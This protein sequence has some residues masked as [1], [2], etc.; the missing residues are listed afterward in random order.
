MITKDQFG[1][2]RHFIF[3]H[4]R[5]F[6][7]KRFAY[8]FEGGSRLAAL[9]ALLCYQNPDG[10]FGHGLELDVI[11]AA[12]APICAE[13]ALNHFD[14]LGA[15]DCDALRQLEGWIL[16]VQREDGALPNPT[17]EIARHPHGPWWLDEDA[18]RA[19]SLAGLLAKMGLGSEEFFR[20]VEGL[21][22]RYE[23][24]VEMGKYDYPLHL[25]LLHSPGAQEH[26]DRLRVVQ[27]ELPGMVRRFRDHHPLLVFS[28]RWVSDDTSQDLL[29]D[30]AR[31]AV[32]DL[33]EDGGIRSPYP[34][35]PWWRPVWTLEVLISLKRF[36][37]ICVSL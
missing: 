20:R 19:F 24:P 11:C 15:R 18:V 14:E 28:Y 6:D 12:S 23:F 5:L 16:S 30:E 9:D 32:A 27:K 8:H 37:F 17:E 1:R 33:D 34:D 21:F 25:Y 31:I 2:A 35:L 22:N 13:L 3:R 7:R 29:E 4:G 10:G 36:G 26:A